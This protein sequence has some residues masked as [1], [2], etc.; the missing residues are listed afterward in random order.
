MKTNSTSK[1]LATI[2]LIIAVFLIFILVRGI[3]GR[4]LKMGKIIH[5]S[6]NISS[7]NLSLYKNYSFNGNNLKKVSVDSS[8]ETIVIADSDSKDVVV[9]LYGEWDK[10]NPTVEL[11]GDSLKVTRPAKSNVVASSHRKIEVLIPRNQVTTLNCNS[12]SG[13]LTVSNLKFE[14]LNINSAS[15]SIRMNDCTAKNVDFNSASGSKKFEDCDFDFLKSKS[16]S[17]SFK[18]SGKVNSFDISSA[19]GSISIENDSVITGDSSIKSAS[20]SIKI[21]LPQDSNF[22]LKCESN[23]GSIHNEF[24]GNSFRNKAHETVGSGGAELKI[25]S[26]SGSIKIEN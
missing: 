12:A 14:N 19:S 15:G 22:V 16:A 2:Y 17:G 1:I 21:A 7:D 11:T 9:N 20:G 18:F 13:G 5:I 3:S 6:S 10:I 24:T 25:K 26:S 4:G 8:S 23:S